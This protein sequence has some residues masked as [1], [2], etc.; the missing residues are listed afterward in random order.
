MSRVKKNRVEHLA[1]EISI[2]RVY[3]CEAMHFRRNANINKILV[4]SRNK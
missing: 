3:A 2:E 1:E 4:A